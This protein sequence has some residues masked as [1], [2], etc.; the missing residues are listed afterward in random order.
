MYYLK[1]KYTSIIDLQNLNHSKTFQN[2]SSPHPVLLTENHCS[3]SD[4]C[5]SKCCPHHQMFSEDNSC[6][7]VSEEKHVWR[8]VEHEQVD[9][10]YHNKFLENYGK[11]KHLYRPD[12]ESVIFLDH[13][14]DYY[15][16]RVHIE[17][18]NF[19]FS[20]HFLSIQYVPPLINTFLIKYLVALTTNQTA[21]QH[22]EDCC[23]LNP[24]FSSL[25]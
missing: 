20:F 1:H 25:T 3:V 11:F 22:S 5:V 12:C 4:H 10:I 13:S 18:L 16:A 17:K 23:M 15:Q 2:F 9:I 6:V 7:N 21:Y 19:S 24:E 14:Y 8:H